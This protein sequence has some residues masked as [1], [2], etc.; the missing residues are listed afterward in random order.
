MI[1]PPPPHT[2]RRAPWRVLCA[3]SALLA[4]SLGA[5][6]ST[7][8]HAASAGGARKVQ[9]FVPPFAYEAYV[10]GELLLSQGNAR[11]AAAQLELATAAPD[12]DAFLLSRL[13]EALYQTGDHD[14]AQRTLREAERVD[15][16][17]LSIW[18]TRGGWAE[19][20]RDL[21]A[22]ERAYQHALRCDPHSDRALLA[23]HRV[24]MAEGQ[25]ERATAL[26]T[27]HPS[28]T[29]A[30]LFALALGSG[31]VAEARHALDSWLSLGVPERAVLQP[32]IEAR[33]ERPALALTLSELSLPGLT[34]AT[35]ARLALSALDAKTARALLEHYL[36]GELGGPETAARLAVLAGEHE[37]AE[38]FAAL[39]VAQAP[40]DPRHALHAE[41]L[42][43]LGETA[44]AL[45]AVSA[46]QEPALRRTMLLRQLTALGLPALARE[47]S[48]Q[49]Q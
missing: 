1:Q 46:I 27:E 43:A 21:P 15:A 5:C 39:A 22:A 23:L 2:S 19:R 17:Q 38:L 44:R 4:T 30:R 8:S 13:A 32:A 36:D 12:E 14:L 49:S 7:T 25:P 45:E 48:E 35:R 6:A 24:L 47:L 28:P 20:E 11:G 33:T 16:C 31:N 42:L 37:R 41:T 29:S 10:R 26:L 3:A 9:P 34:P 40:S 18:T